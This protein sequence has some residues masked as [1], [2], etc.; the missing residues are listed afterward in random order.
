M[1]PYELSRSKE[2]KEEFTRLMKE[3]ITFTD[4]MDNVSA[5]TV[6]LF[7]RKKSAVKQVQDF[8]THAS[9]AL[10]T[11]RRRYAISNAT[12]LHKISG[13]HGDPM[14]TNDTSIKN[15]LNRKVREPPQ[16]IFYK[17]AVFEAT[18]N[19]AQYQNSQLLMMLDVP[20]NSDVIRKNPME[21]FAAPEN[22][23]VQQTLFTLEDPPSKEELLKDGWKKVKVK[24]NIGRNRTESN[25]TASRNQYGLTHIGACTVHK[26]QGRTL[27]IPVAIEV[28]IIMGKC[29][30]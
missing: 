25:V 10:S 26:T 28:S 1:S 6:R 19:T 22:A 3:N 12:D 18:T 14:P 17:G 13:T 24:V 23:N 2:L 21:L 15:M 8:V 29:Q 30:S 7:H 27:R 11:N 16:L 5:E 20:S 9:Q 4:S